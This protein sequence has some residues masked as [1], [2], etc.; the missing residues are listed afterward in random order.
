LILAFCS[1][2]PEA[3]QR[4]YE[5]G[6]HQCGQNTSSHLAKFGNLWAVYLQE[7]GPNIVFNRTIDPQEVIDFIEAN[8]DLDKKTGGYVSLKQKLSTPDALDSLRE[9]T[10]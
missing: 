6:S 7:H 5:C 9:I 1:Q 3:S 4:E 8:F 2:V 10:G